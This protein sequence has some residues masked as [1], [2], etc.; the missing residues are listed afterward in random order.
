[1]GIIMRDFHISADGVELKTV[2]ADT[3]FV[4]AVKESSRHAAQRAQIT[5]SKF[6]KSPENESKFSVKKAPERNHQL[7]QLLEG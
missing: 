4:E 7:E 2:K 3:N 6:A 1:M 5:E